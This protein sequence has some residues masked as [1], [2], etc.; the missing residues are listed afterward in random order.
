MSVSEYT[1]KF[2]TLARFAPSLVPTD[3]VRKM[4]YMHELNMDIVSQVDS[5]DDGPR[6]YANAVQRALQIAGWCEGDQTPAPKPV[7]ATPSEVAGPKQS[8][9]RKRFRPKS[10]RPQRGDRMRSRKARV[11]DLRK[12]LETNHSR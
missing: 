3:Q 1:T 5:G 10:S 12:A 2:D 8:E 4:K 7:S 6:T 9:S 11:T